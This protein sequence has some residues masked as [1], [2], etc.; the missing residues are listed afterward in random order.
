MSSDPE[1]LIVLC[2]GLQGDHRE[3]AYLERKINER[4]SSTKTPFVVLNSKRNSEHLASLGIM[5]C[6]EELVTQYASF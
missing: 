4:A 1:L 5:K 6:A 3:L 2:H